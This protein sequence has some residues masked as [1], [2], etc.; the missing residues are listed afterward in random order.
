MVT[1]R[2][3][4]YYIHGPNHDIDEMSPII[5]IM[6]FGSFV[7]LEDRPFGQEFDENINEFSILKVQPALYYQRQYRKIK[8][9]Y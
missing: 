7:E 3:N 4:L 2:G 5:Q 9:T 8:D 6:E 1:M